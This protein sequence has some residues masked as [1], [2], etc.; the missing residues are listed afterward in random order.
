MVNGELKRSFSN[1]HSEISIVSIY[2]GHSQP[3]VPAVKH[4]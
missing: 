4:A 2:I 3:I 1:Q